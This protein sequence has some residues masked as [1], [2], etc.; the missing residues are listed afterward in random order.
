MDGSDWPN[1]TAAASL[2]ELLSE[3]VVAGDRVVLGSGQFPKFPVPKGGSAD[4]PLTITGVDTGEGLPSIKGRWKEINPKYHAH[5]WSAITLAD[6]VSHMRIGG[7]QISGF[8][9]GVKATNNRDVEM[10]D[11]SITQCREGVSLNGLMDSAIRNCQVIGYTKRGIRFNEGCHDLVVADVVVVCTGGN[12]AWPTEAFPYGFAVEDGDGN[13][14][15]RFELCAARNNV[16]P[17]EPGKYWNGDGFLAE[18]NAYNL[19]YVD[20]ESVKNSDGGW[21]DKTR[22]PHL[23]GCVAA[24]NKRGFRLWNV[25]GDRQ[26]PARLENCRGV[27]NKSSVLSFEVLKN[28]DNPEAFGS[29]LVGDACLIK[30]EGKYWFY[31]RRRQLGKGPAHPKLRVAIS[32]KPGGPYVKYAGNPAIPGNHEV[33]VWPQGKG[34][35][36]M[37]GT[38]G[39]KEIVSSIMYNEDGLNFT[40]THHVIDVP[41][42]AGAYRPEAFTDNGLGKQIEWGV[43]IGSQRG[44]LPFIQRFDLGTVPK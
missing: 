15:I 1:A 34:V 29:H 10:C 27:Y 19:T 42:A 36:A 20:C 38:T 44:S 33:L 30:R 28:S 35:A 14:S 13:H 3:K 6:R 9:Y 41:H 7:L 23:I 21:D 37:I 31:Y 40:K 22:A 8:V 5:S 18:N 25:H 43:H 17:S 16:F 39:P 26:H 2:Q 12:D 32:D 24:R 11:F 4:Q